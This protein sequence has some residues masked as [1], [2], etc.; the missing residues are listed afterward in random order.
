LFGSNREKEIINQHI[1]AAVCYSS[2]FVLREF[3]SLVT[4]TLIEYYYFLALYPS[5]GEAT[6]EFLNEYSFKNRKIKSL[7][8]TLADELSSFKTKEKAKITI[9]LYIRQVKTRFFEIITY[10]IDHTQCP[11]AKLEIPMGETGLYSYHNNFKC[12]PICCLE[13]F[14]KNRKSKLQQIIDIDAQLLKQVDSKKRDEFKN[15][16]DI[17][18]K[19]LN[20]K[21]ITET[22]YKKLGDT[23]IAMETPRTTCLLTYDEIFKLLCP[24]IGINLQIL[25]HPPKTSKNIKFNKIKI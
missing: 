9:E 25:K 16:L 3:H 1:G 8:F 22:D 19:F 23:I 12:P 15:L 13:R 4:I 2:Y 7:V 17:Y 21:T 10:M 11:V 18:D 24:P 14:F 6:K 20:N 5:V